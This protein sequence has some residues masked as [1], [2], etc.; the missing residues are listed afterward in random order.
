MEAKLNGVLPTPAAH[1]DILE[2]VDVTANT[3]IN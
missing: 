2:R 3:S 1:Q